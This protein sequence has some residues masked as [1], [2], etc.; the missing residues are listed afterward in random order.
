MK[1]FINSHYSLRMFKLIYCPSQV[2]VTQKYSILR[3]ETWSS[4]SRSDCIL[5]PSYFLILNKKY[6]SLLPPSKRKNHSFLFCTFIRF[7]K[8]YF[9][10]NKNMKKPYS[11]PSPTLV[12]PHLPTHP[13]HLLFSD[14]A[15][16]SSK[17]FC[18]VYNTYGRQYQNL[19]TDGWF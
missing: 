17:D 2:W 14:N 4:N 12:P 18:S 15:F 16:A 5:N 9:S 1:N 10:Y 19:V 8:Y 13:T 7:L 6:I 3:A 11:F